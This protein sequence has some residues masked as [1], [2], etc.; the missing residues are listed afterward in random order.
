MHWVL[1]QPG[2][3]LSRFHALAEINHVK[4]SL[5][6]ERY[7]LDPWHGGELIK[8]DLTVVLENIVLAMGDELAYAFDS[9]FG[10]DMTSWKEID[11]L[12]TV[13]MVVAQVASRYT[14]GLSL[15]KLPFLPDRNGLMIV[16]TNILSRQK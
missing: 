8:K 15:C 13:R 4:Y 14:V 7:V 10:T 1:A 3:V 2:S 12:E 5:G 11:L 9:R 16:V 6:D